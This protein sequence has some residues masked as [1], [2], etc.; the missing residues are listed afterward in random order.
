[1]KRVKTYTFRHAPTRRRPPRGARPLGHER[2]RADR[3]GLQPPRLGSAR[4]RHGERLHRRLRRRHGSVLEPGRPRAAAQA[5]ALG[6]ELDPWPQPRRRGR[7]HPGR[8]GDLHAHELVLP[9]HLPRFREPRRAREPLGQARHLPGLLAPPLHPRLPRGRVHDP[10]ARGPGRAPARSLRHQR[11]PGR[12]RQSRFPGGGGAAVAA[13]HDRR[14]LQLLARRLEGR[15]L[16]QR[17]PARGA[18]RDAVRDHQPDQP[19]ARRQLQPRRHAHLP[20]LQHRPR[21]SGPPLL[22]LHGACERR[23]QRRARDGHGGRTGFPAVPA[24]GRRR[25]APGGRPSAGRWPWT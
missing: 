24:L 23:G 9:E 20:A 21:P 16:E 25:A 2:R 12:R 5:R 1:M 4:G 14:Q 18:G 13:L 10:R 11:R 8:P 15:R 19:G 6:R 3:P 7:S 17:D 22:G